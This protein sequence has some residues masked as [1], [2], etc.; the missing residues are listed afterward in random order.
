MFLSFFFF[1]FSIVLDLSTNPWELESS[2]VCAEQ[3]F[4]FRD[5][6]SEI[7]FQR[8]CFRDSVSEI[9]FQRFC[10]RDSVSEILFQRF[11]FNGDNCPI[12]TVCLLNVIS[13]CMQWEKTSD[14]ETLSPFLSVPPFSG[15]KSLISPCS[16]KKRQSPFLSVP[17]FSVSKSLTSP[18]SGKERLSQQRILRHH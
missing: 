13:P 14:K 7:L 4:C 3:R 9:L 1:F 17:P 2:L 6:V 11:C 15:S 18:C 16:E 12:I 8:F 10:F 5:S